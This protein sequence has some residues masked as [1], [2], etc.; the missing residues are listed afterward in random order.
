MRTVHLYEFEF[1]PPINW[2]HI[3]GASLQFPA[4]LMTAENFH[5]EFG[6]ISLT[7]LPRYWSFWAV[8]SLPSANAVWMC[9]GAVPH[10]HV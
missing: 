5:Q 2:D 10:S 9:W 1:S 4:Q 6:G 8:S 7:A 3:C